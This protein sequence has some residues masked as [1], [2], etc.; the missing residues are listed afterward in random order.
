MCWARRYHLLCQSDDFGS[1]IEIDVFG[2]WLDV[3]RLFDWNNPDMGIPVSSHK[4]V[5]W[6]I[7]ENGGQNVIALVW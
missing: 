1:N 6:T 4:F 7:V 2:R 5:C 3:S